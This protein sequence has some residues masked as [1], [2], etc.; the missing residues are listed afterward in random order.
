MCES[1]IVDVSERQVP[2]TYVG[3]YLIHVLRC[4]GSGQLV[5]APRPRC[6][7]FLTR[8]LDALGM[9]KLACWRSVR[10]LQE[11]YEKASFFKSFEVL[12]DSCGI[13]ISL[14]PE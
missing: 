2:T 13:I 5:S 7:S 4:T 11:M 14:L 6:W 12:I 1:A 8:P 3:M 10:A 9:S